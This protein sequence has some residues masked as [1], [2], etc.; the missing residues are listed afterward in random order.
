M[1]ALA[2]L[3]LVGALIA[4]GVIA[5]VN[6][7]RVPAPKTRIIEIPADSIEL[8]CIQRSKKTFVCFIIEDTRQETSANAVHTNSGS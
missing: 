7:P 1:K 4:G 5:L 6:Y 3:A 2:V 8:R